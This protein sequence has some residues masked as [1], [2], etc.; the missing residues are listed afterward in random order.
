MDMWVDGSNAN[1]CLLRR[2][3]PAEEVPIKRAKD[4]RHRLG[5]FMSWWRIIRKVTGWDN[6]QCPSDHLVNGFM[7]GHSF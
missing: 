5:I 7:M 1:T 2:S 3:A 6:P 4:H